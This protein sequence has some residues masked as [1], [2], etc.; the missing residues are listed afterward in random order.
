P[1]PDHAPRTAQP[2]QPVRSRNRDP[3]TS[4]TPPGGPP[5]STARTPAQKAEPPSR[6]ADPGMASDQPRLDAVAA[7]A[8]RPASARSTG[9]SSGGSRTSKS[10]PLIAT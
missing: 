5:P 1:G 4:S 8:R 2:R 3:P 9:T 7:R 10:K 6:Q